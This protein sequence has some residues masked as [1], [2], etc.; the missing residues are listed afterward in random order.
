MQ[1]TIQ[2]TRLKISALRPK[3]ATVVTFLAHRAEEEVLF[4]INF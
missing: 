4:S 2:S 3:A 1:L